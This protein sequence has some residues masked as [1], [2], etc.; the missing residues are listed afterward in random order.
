MIYDQFCLICYLWT[1]IY[2][3]CT[4][5]CDLS[6]SP[7]PSTDINTVFN[8]H[9]MNMWPP[10]ASQTITKSTQNCSKITVIVIWGS[11]LCA[12]L[13]AQRLTE[14]RWLKSPLYMILTLNLPLL[15]TLIVTSDVVAMSIDSIA[16]SADKEGKKDSYSRKENG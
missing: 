5:T 15:S 12:V 1:F 6:P 3:Q 7:T 16:V 4:I 2:V 11:P 9:I 8:I 14:H 10:P 13:S